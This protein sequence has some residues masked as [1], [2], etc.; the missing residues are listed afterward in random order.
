M[1]TDEFS[2]EEINLIELAKEY[3]D[4]DKAR[5]LMESLRWPDG[6]VCPHCGA[7]E[8]Y[9]L[10]PKKDSSTRKGVIKCA[11]C[12]K[13]YSVTVGTVFEGSHVPLSKWLQA[14]FIICS[15]KK[16]VSAHQLHRMLKITYKTAW[17]LAHR[18]RYAMGQEP[19]NTLLKGTI[20]ADETYVGGRTPRAPGSHLKNKTPV[21]ALIERG[22]KLKAQVVERVNAKN[23]KA[24]LEKHTE[25]DI[26]L[27][28]D[29]S[30]VYTS[31]K[32]QGV[33][34][35]HFSVNHGV[36]EYARGWVHVNTCESFFAILKR[37]VY[38]TF[39]HLSRKHL[40][41]YAS[42]F[43]YRWNA[44]RMTDGERMKAMFTLVNGRRLFYKQPK[45]AKNPFKTLDFPID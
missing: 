42:E 12:R 43:Q 1:K 13:P 23:L 30:V 11:K 6:P 37:G 21:V 45:K 34:K 2:P 24:V 26:V 33:V 22:G 32:K 25:K 20:E 17:F 44:R 35:N 3:S 8:H 14:I 28:S 39:H 16:G 27:V 36:K 4:E 15:S 9:R 5:S 40:H 31:L 38:G 19:L 41:R 10:T 7:K 29:E 18:V